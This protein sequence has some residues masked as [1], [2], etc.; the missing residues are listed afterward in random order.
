MVE[1]EPG[2]TSWYL[3]PAGGPPHL[4][5]V[6]CPGS[7]LWIGPWDG[8]IAAEGLLSPGL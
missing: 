1:E 6:Q 8:P 2:I 7:L 3:L 4:V 5:A